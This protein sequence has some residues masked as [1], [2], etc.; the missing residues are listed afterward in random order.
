FFGAEAFDGFV[1][2]VGDEALFGGGR[3]L[4]GNEGAPD[5]EGGAE[6]GDHEQTVIANSV[7]LAKRDRFEQ[8]E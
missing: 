6:D 4:L 5:N 1:D 2:A 7:L 3:L 8:V